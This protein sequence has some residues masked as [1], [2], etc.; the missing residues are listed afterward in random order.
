VP[1]ATITVRAPGAELE[2]ASPVEAML[3]TGSTWT[4]VPRDIADE[5]HLPED[6]EQLVGTLEG[7]DVLYKACVADLRVFHDEVQRARMLIWERDQAL[8]GRD[9][10]HYFVLTFDGPAKAWRVV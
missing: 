10:L 5:Q 7:R 9:V 2:R 3:D 4:F 1:I 8:L 6:G